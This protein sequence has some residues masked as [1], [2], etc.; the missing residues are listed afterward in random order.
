[1]SGVRCSA[2]CRRAE[3]IDQRVGSFFRSFFGEKVTGIERR[4]LHVRAPPLPKCDRSGLLAVP[5]T[6]RTVR[7]PHDQKRTGDSASPH[8][9]RLVMFSHSVRSREDRSRPR[10][11][12]EQAAGRR[13]ATSSVFAESRATTARAARRRASARKY[14]SRRSGCRQ[15]RSYRESPNTDPTGLHERNVKRQSGSWLRSAAA[16]A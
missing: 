9:I 11:S 12:G 5:T 1:M 2:M 8:A 16:A 4:T 6:E 3:E 13:C 15:Q 7:A 10:R 14:S